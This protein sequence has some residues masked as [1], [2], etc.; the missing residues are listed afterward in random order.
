MSTIYTLRVTLYVSLVA[1]SS[2]WCTG[3]G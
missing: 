1:A 3:C 2:L